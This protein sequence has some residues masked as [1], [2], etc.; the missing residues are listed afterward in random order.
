M[1]APGS[2]REVQPAPTIPT[3]ASRTT[4]MTAPTNG[5]ASAAALPSFPNPTPTTTAQYADYPLATSYNPSPMHSPPHPSTSAT[6]SG[7]GGGGAMHVED[8]FSALLSGVTPSLF[9][10]VGMGMGMGGGGGYFGGLD[11]FAAGGGGES[12]RWEDLETDMGMGLGQ[13]GRG[14]YGDF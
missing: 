12:V 9:D 2:P 10:G 14:L 1:S 11:G 4:Q 6:G 7:G 13:G 3:L 8:P 5:F